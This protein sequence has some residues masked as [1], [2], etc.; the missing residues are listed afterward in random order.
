METKTKV[1]RRPTALTES[2]LQPGFLQKLPKHSLCYWPLSTPTG[3]PHRSQHGLAEAQIWSSLV[4]Y[5]NGSPRPNSFTRLLGP[6]P[7]GFSHHLTFSSHVTS[8]QQRLCRVSYSP[9]GNKVVPIELLMLLNQL[10]LPQKAV[11]TR[12]FPYSKVRLLFKPY[13]TFHLEA[14]PISQGRM[15]HFPFSVPKHFYDYF[16]G[17]SLPI[18]LFVY[19]AYVLYI[20][21]FNTKLP[22]MVQHAAVCSKYALGP[23]SLLE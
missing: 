11:P 21:L 4:L 9:F 16:Y 17:T 7:P 13:L 22:P 15:S 19:T 3:P 5:S 12:A 23:H 6:S 18:K 8:P 10:R 2:Q 20:H 1:K 14:A